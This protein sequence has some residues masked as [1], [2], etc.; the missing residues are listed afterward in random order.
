V[1]DLESLVKRA[2]SG[3]LDAFGEIVTRFQDMACGCAYAVLGDFHLLDFSDCY[4]PLHGVVSPNSSATFSRAIWCLRPT[5]IPSRVNA[6]TCSASG[7]P[8]K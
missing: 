2:G 6:S 4:R 7:P 1:D 5:G 3:D 8:G